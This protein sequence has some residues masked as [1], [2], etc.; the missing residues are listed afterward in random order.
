[1]FLLNKYK[2]KNVVAAHVN[3]H[4]RN[5][6]DND[7]NIVEA[8]CKKYDIPFEVFNVQAAS[9]GNFQDW[10]RKV[11]Y[12]FFKEIY[13]KYDCEQLITAHHKDDFLE[14]AMLQF[15]SGRTPKYFGIQQNIVIDGMNI[16]RPYV[17]KFWKDEIKDELI[18]SKTPFAVDYT[19]E[20]P[21]YERN[22]IRIELSQLSK[23]E[24]QKDFKWFVSANKMLTIKNKR[25]IAQFNH[26]EKTNFSV[27]FFR[28][29]KNDETEIAYE[30]LHKMFGEVKISGGKIKNF[31]LFICG[32]EGG[33]TF[34]I[35]SKNRVTKTDGF[36]KCTIQK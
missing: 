11:R 20:Q 27:K 25:V 28:T 35:D 22:K 5:D 23:S 6:S 12:N 4:K 8:F 2:N 36:L 18:S 14:T 10:A 33:K 7:Q 16:Y 3:Y 30:Y 13:H 1:M 32:P 15:K 29:F 34:I 26:W 19:N 24:K 17:T 21:I 9:I 31:V